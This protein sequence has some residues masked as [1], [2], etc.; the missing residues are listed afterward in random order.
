[1]RQ[2]LLALVDIKL[3]DEVDCIIGVKMVDLLGD[4]LCRHVGNEFQTVVL[5]K[6]HQDIGCRIV[7]EQTIEILG[8]VNL[9]VL[10]EF[11]DIGGME[12]SEFPDCLL[13]VVGMDYPANMLEIFGSIFLH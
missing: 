9:E 3:L 7:V 10:V 11:S 8:L 13:L 5:I 4:L 1:M 12:I 2:D 6:L